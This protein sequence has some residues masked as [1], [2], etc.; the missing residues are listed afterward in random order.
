[1]YFHSPVCAHDVCLIKHRDSC[2]STF[3]FLKTVRGIRET[4]RCFVACMTLSGAYLECIASN[5]TMIDELER[6]W[7]EAAVA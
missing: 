6:I 5:S 7:K 2:T 1:M 3:T 4:M